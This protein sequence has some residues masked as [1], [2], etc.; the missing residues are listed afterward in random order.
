MKLLR[1]LTMR[2]HTYGR[3]AL[4]S[5][6]V[7]WLGVSFVSPSYATSTRYELI[8]P[9]GEV[10]ITTG[11]FVVNPD[12]STPFQTW[13]FNTI[14]GWGVPQ[15]ELLSTFFQATSGPDLLFQYHTFL[16]TRFFQIEADTVALTYSVA[17]DDNCSIFG[18]CD[19][20]FDQS[21]SLRAS[22]TSVP[23]PAILGLLTIGLLA[24]AGSRWLLRR[25]A[26]Q[27]LG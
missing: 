23:E 10:A 7:L 22:A 12:S 2:H 24:I 25:G 4:L 1:A 13:I 21:G 6:A 19:T 3:W 5:A 11:E 8:P 16:N 9:L 14:L 18:A 17:L 27:Q 15:T 20:S 26:R